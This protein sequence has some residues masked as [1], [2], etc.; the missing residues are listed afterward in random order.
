MTV[1]HSSSGIEASTV[2]ITFDNETSGTINDTSDFHGDGV[3]R[4][5][6]GGNK[7][8]WYYEGS[9]TLTP[10][11]QPAQNAQ[12]LTI[13]IGNDG[14]VTFNGEKNISTLNKGNEFLVVAH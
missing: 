3:I 11:Q 6:N 12:N 5:Q 14:S 13:T 10:N 4:K 1:Q 9:W 7:G 2:T 8:L